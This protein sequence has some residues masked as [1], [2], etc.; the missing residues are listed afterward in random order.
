MFDECA[1]PQGT[2][3]SVARP[4]P[5]RSEEARESK[6]CASLSREERGAYLLRFVAVF[7]AD[8]LADFLA[9]F[10]AVFFF[11]VF[12]TGMFAPFIP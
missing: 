5:C 9:D 3:H 7:F 4:A 8:F 6:R 1:T 12:F 2:T 10:F 11:A